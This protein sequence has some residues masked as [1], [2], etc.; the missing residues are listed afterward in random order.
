MPFRCWM[1]PEM[2]RRCRGSGKFLAGHAHIAVQGDVFEVSATGREEPTAAA[3]GLGQGLNK[4]H[5]LLLAMPLPAETT[6]SA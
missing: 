1:A 2:P 3:G 5:V 4:L 6:R